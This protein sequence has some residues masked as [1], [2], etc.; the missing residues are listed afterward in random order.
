MWYSSVFSLSSGGFDVLSEELGAIMEL[1]AMDS[2]LWV[3]VE[4]ILNRDRKGRKGPHHTS[5]IDLYI[6]LLLNY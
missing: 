3:T 5:K 2:T 1:M 4:A 6:K